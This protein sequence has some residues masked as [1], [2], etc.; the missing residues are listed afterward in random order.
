MLSKNIKL[1]KLK[2]NSAIYPLMILAI[3]LV[4]SCSDGSMSSS[5]KD[6]SQ[7]GGQN[8]SDSGWV[9]LFNGKDL[10]GWNELEGKSKFTA[11]DEEIIGTTIPNNPNSVLC[12]LDVKDDSTLNS[13]V[14]IRS[15]LNKKGEVYGYQIEIDPSK[16]A[17][18]GGIYDC[19]RRGWMVN[20]ENRPEKQ[21]AFK[22]GQWNHYKIKANGDTLQ[23]W[24][25]NIPIA[26]MVDTLKD[27]IGFIGLQA[28]G[29]LQ[30]GLRVLFKNIRIKILKQQGFIT[31][32]L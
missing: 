15:H 23:S 21:K 10:S 19:R 26:M 27:S 11:K 14:Q 32:I 3:L 8:T 4:I 29:N 24:I 25:N 6:G 20:L 17:W 31:K 18:S 22:N 2:L 9:S 1:R 30:G 28:D 13:G 16:R 5:V 12:E 7:T